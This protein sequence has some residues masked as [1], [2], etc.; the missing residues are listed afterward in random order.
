MRCVWGCIRARCRVFRLHRSRC[1]R[2]RRYLSCDV[3]HSPPRSPSLPSHSWFCAC[4]TR[5]LFVCLILMVV[6]LL[7]ALTHSVPQSYYEAPVASTQMMMVPQ[8]QQMVMAP[9][10]QMVMVPAPQQQMVMMAA[11]Q[12]LT[13]TC[14]RLGSPWTVTQHEHNTPCESLPVPV[15]VP[16]PPRPGVPACLVNVFFLPPILPLYP[17][18]RAAPLGALVFCSTLHRPLFSST[19]PRDS[20]RW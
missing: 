13:V 20:A 9:Q 7:R 12:V 17:C 18:W 11:P 10:P 15:L 3:Y 5:C 4:T 16:S 14:L 19:H 2:L 8:Q 6:Y 1:T